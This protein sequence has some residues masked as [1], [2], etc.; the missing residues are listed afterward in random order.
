MKKTIFSLMISVSLFACN[1]AEQKEQQISENNNVT[2]SK[3]GDVVSNSIEKD[4]KADP[5]E[6]KAEIKFEDLEFN[7]G[8][9]K[10]G[11]KVRHAYKFKN[12]GKIPLIIKEAKAS[13]GCTTP[14]VPKDP[15]APGAE[16]EIVAEFDSKGRAG[17]V[18][19]T[20]S[21]FSNTNPTEVIL[22]LKGNVKADAVPENGPR[23]N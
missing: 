7:F 4:P 3:K 1:K 21:V 5:N 16:A 14:T 23:K 9:V 2:I 8:E 18:S 20:I 22:S 13:C 10:E 19:K 12:T 15:I 6:P 17:V 11:V